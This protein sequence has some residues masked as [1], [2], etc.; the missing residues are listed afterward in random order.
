VIQA[1]GGIQGV[2]Y[3]WDTSSG[4]LIRE[5]TAHYCSIHAISFHSSFLA[6]AAA[7][8]A[9][10]VWDLTLLLQSSSHAISQSDTYNDAI[11]R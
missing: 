5:W 6:T 1:G 11:Y 2:A 10:R 8:G 9:V 3:L 7:D 4:A